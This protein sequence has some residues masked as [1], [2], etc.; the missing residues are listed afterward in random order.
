MP[1]LDSKEQKGKHVHDKTLASKTNLN[2]TDVPTFAQLQIKGQ[3]GK[4]HTINVPRSA[5]VLDLKILVKEETGIPP[6]E[7]R[8]I[9][10]IAGKV[11]EDH[12]M[13]FD[14]PRLQNGSVLFLVLRLPGGGYPGVEFTDVTDRKG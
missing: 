4:T 1:A 7:Q 13:V 12:R 9:Y 3:E 8:L 11:L 2:P 5:S 14:Y 6:E 10:G